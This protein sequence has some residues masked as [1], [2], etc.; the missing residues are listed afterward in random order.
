MYQIFILF[1]KRLFGHS[2]TYF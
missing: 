1:A 2:F